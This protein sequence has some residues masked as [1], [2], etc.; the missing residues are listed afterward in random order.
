MDEHGSWA[1]GVGRVAES[2]LQLSGRA[3]VGAD[4]RSHRAFWPPIRRCAILSSEHHPL[5]AGRTLSSQVK[6]SQVKSS[7]NTLPPAV[8]DSVKPCVA[9]FGTDSHLGTVRHAL[10][11]GSLA[12]QLAFVAV[13]PKLNGLAGGG[14]VSV[15]SKFSSEF[16][17]FTVPPRANFALPKCHFSTHDQV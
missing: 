3:L 13:P 14:A 15:P 1:D 9:D 16:S 2:T 4:C 17:Y 6:A 10:T 5:K 11:G 12:P 7:Q 8:W